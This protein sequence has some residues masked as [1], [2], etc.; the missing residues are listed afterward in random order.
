MKSIYFLAF[1]KR[2]TLKTTFL[3]KINLIPWLMP[4]GASQIC[5]KYKC[6]VTKKGKGDNLK[7]YKNWSTKN[8][9]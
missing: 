9:R 7:S 8:E 6:L 5:S 2:L 4:T 1:A 3:Q